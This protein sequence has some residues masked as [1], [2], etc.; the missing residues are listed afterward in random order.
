MGLTVVEDILRVME[1]EAPLYPANP[2]VW[3]HRR[4][5]P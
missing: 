2:E 3:P 4:I 5:V 1:G